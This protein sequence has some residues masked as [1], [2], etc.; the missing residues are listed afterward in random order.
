MKVVAACV[1]AIAMI[2]ACV[3]AVPARAYDEA[4]VAGGGTVAGQVVFHGTVPT[5]AV[6][7]NKDVET[8][9]APRQDPLVDVGPGGGVANALV[10]LVDV[11]KGKPWPA[12]G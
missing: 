9:G 11:A 7:P 2:S 1:C 3:A 8:C 6:I 4:A 10:Y 12:V 5:R